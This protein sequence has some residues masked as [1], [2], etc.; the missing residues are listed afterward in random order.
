MTDTVPPPPPPPHPP[1]LPK[2]WTKLSLPHKV[3]LRWRLKARRDQL[4]PTQH[5][6]CDNTPAECEQLIAQAKAEMP[7]RS[8]RKEREAWLRERGHRPWFIWIILAGR[9]WGK[10]RTGAEDTLKFML[11]HPYSRV[12]LVAATFADGRDTMVEGESGI[13]ALLPRRLLLHWNRSI[14]ELVLMNGAR[15]KVFSAEEPE[16]LRGPQHH[17]AWCDELAAWARLKKT[18]DQ[19][20]FGLRLGENPQV[21]ITT[22]PRALKFLRKMKLKSLNSNEGIVI[23]TGTT[24]ENAANLANAALATLQDTYANTRLGRQELYAEILDDAEGGV[25]YRADIDRSRVEMWQFRGNEPIDLMSRVVVGVDP[26]VTATQNSDETGIV[27]GGISNGMCPVC[28]RAENPRGLAHAFIIADETPGRVST[29]QWADAAVAAYRRYKADKVVAE[30]NN[31]GDLVESELTKSHINLPVKQVRATRGKV[32]RA[33][34]I[35]ALYEKGMVHHIGSFPKLEDQLVS[36]GLIEDEDD[37][38]EAP[39]DDDDWKSPDRADAA[40]WLLTELM[41][42]SEATLLVGTASDHRGD[43]SR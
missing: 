19:L 22:T 40:V 6:L 27:V 11:E 15:A 34:P 9:G 39:E 32:I 7:S 13:L 8:R 26:A 12:A 31:G 24:F 37:G 35:G 3:R 36:L 20:M 43:G 2:D 25:I 33:E 38:T 5:V 21:L 1:A 14:G 42:P 28:T 41:L 17:R 10:T 23:T 30:V 18:W 16:R 29:A 4:T